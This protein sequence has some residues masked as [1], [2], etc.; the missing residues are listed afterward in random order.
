M[1]ESGVTLLEL[2][3]TLTIVM[4]PFSTGAAGVVPTYSG[5][6]DAKGSCAGAGE[7]DARVERIVYGPKGDVA[8]YT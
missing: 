4:V 3:I 7:G 6:A 1:K 8:V 2:L 5:T